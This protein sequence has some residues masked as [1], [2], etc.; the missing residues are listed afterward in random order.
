MAPVLCGGLA[1]PAGLS[2]VTCGVSTHLRGADVLLSCGKE[3]SAGDDQAGFV[4]AT[5]VP[6]SRS[7]AP[8]NGIEIDH[9][10]E[11]L[12]PAH[13]LSYSEPAN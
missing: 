8:W 1:G 7:R 10:L 4:R 9:A 6:A 5:A 13:Q 2:G 3:T 12:G 11:K